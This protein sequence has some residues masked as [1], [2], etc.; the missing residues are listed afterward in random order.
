M[1]T[2]K[3]SWLDQEERGSTF[4][5][6]AIIWIART[7]G[8][9]VARL[10]LFPISLYFVIFSVKAREGSRKFL[11]RVLE[12][13][14]SWLDIFKHYYTFAA[15][16][17]D[18]VFLLSEDFDRFDI[19]VH[20]ADQ[21]H[22]WLDE[23]QG[24][25]LLGA[26]FGSFEVLRSFGMGKRNLPVNI[27]FH[28]INS[29]KITQLLHAINPKIAMSVIDI[30]RPD[31]I[32]KVKEKIENGEVVG[33]LGDRI[34]GGEKYM[35]CDFLGGKAPFPWGPLMVAS[36][37]HAPVALFFGVYRGGKRYDLHFEVLAERIDIK[38][39]EREEKMQYWL[40]R[41]ADR[42]EYYCK[43]EPFN[44]FN[45]YD[46]WQETEAPKP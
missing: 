9:S 25:I 13:P 1:T 20:N 7:M 11:T 43:K 17:L 40:Q 42:L 24:I 28:K 37:T 22:K 18:R 16:I 5:I 26:H 39:K 46:F 32:I 29:Q 36:V 4:M 19:R 33:I 38:R 2:D 23:G 31:T 44:W 45:F 21:L 34:T 3:R 35:E 27:L 10:F 12:K 8:R 41:Y 15:T 6:Q 14:V 30:G